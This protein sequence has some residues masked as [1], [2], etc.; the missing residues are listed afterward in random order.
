MIIERAKIKCY[1]TKNGNKYE[2]VTQYKGYTI[3]QLVVKAREVFKA[4]LI[5]NDISD[6][7]YK[8]RPLDFGVYISDGHPYGDNSYSIMISVF[9]D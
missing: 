7:E 3:E 1:G 9:T 2:L 5:I 8:K 4:F 6:W